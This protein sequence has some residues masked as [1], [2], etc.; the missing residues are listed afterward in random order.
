MK[1]L[2]LRASRSATPFKSINTSS[3]S[4]SDVTNNPESKVPMIRKSSNLMVWKE[5]L[6]M[7]RKTSALEVYKPNF[8]QRVKED[9]VLETQEKNP[10]TLVSENKV[11]IEENPNV[12]ENV[13]KNK[14]AAMLNT[15]LYGTP[16]KFKTEHEKNYYDR[17][18]AF[19][20]SIASRT[21]AEQDWDSNPENRFIS[22]FDEDL[23]VKRYD[24]NPEVK[25]IFR[26]NRNNSNKT[27]SGPK[28]EERYPNIITYFSK[29]V[30]DSQG[31]IIPVSALNPD[32][33]SEP[34]PKVLANIVYKHV[35]DTNKAVVQ[36]G[37]E[38]DSD[39]EH[40]SLNRSNMLIELEQKEKK[41][42]PLTSA[43][44][45]TT[46]PEL[47]M[48]WGKPGEYIEIDT[49]KVRILLPS[50]I[51]NLILFAANDEHA[52]QKTSFKWREH[53]KE[54]WDEKSLQETEKLLIEHGIDPNGDW[55]ERE[56][57]AYYTLIAGEWLVI[58]AT[59][60]EVA[61][62]IYEAE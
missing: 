50:Q 56:K 59:P 34:F 32:I 49:A 4:N 58:G 55:T 37:Y 52:N 3:A 40:T 25:N 18:L 5:N 8:L 33:F 54:L 45:N 43:S 9:S 11:E 44:L 53:K 57:T 13:F 38:F 23:K 22:C 26:S 42:S 6:P 36:R 14:M 51:V 19:F 2:T 21:S 62:V 16:P 60:E 41:A 46:R 47:F 30:V 29:S 20:A 15:F 10:L 17:S 27:L 28:G 12:E 24:K 31:K 35:A 7:V 48:A 1:S 61:R 39:L